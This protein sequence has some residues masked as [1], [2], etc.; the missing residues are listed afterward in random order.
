MRV[1]ANLRLN[2]GATVAE[3]AQALREIPQTATIRVHTYTADRPGEISYSE[4][5]FTWDTKT[6]PY[7]GIRRATDP[8][9]G[10]QPLTF[11]PISGQRDTSSNQEG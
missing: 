6:K 3:L 10:E 11:N 9:Y 4:L 1:T 5:E 7:T 2:D 8:V